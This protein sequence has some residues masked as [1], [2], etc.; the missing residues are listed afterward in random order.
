MDIESYLHSSDFLS[1]AESD[2]H[3]RSLIIL[4]IVFIFNKAI[5]AP[6]VFFQLFVLLYK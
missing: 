2:E 4:R 3:T 5:A 6:F 1:C